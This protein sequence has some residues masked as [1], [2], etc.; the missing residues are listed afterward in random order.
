MPGGGWGIDT[1]KIVKIDK[2]NISE[3]IMTGVSLNHIREEA[4]LGGYKRLFESGLEKLQSLNA[5]GSCDNIIS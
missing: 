3:M 4:R 2:V 1:T 5:A